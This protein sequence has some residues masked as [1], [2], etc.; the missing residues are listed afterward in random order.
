MEF[1]P[2]MALVGDLVNVLSPPYVPTQSASHL[3]GDS[4]GGG[5]EYGGRAA[6]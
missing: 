1:R 3:M 6:R 5:F 2:P 4:F